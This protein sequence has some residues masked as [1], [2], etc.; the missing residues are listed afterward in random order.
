MDC[1]A[2]PE[3]KQFRT[4]GFELQDA[5][6]ELGQ[7]ETA[8][9]NKADSFQEIVER[10]EQDN[11]CFTQAATAMKMEADPRASIAERFRSTRD[12]KKN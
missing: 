3:L 5:Y 9:L 7:A 2:C 11:R 6:E 1:V 12:C 8:L 10:V 4:L